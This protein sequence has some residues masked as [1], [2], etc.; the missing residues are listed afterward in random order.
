M[1]DAQQAEQQKYVTAT[2]D[3]FRKAIAAGYKDF[4]Q[5]Q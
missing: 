1:T 3:T 4:A 2:L 5:I